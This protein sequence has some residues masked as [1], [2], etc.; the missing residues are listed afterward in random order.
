M[1]EGFGVFS[2][3]FSRTSM[4]A[5]PG[6]VFTPLVAFDAGHLFYSR[7]ESTFRNRHPVETR[8]AWSTEKSAVLKQALQA[9]VETLRRRGLLLK[10]ATS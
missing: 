7:F 6:G 2:H 10:I 5:S 9:T 1:G 8:S 4:E 3:H